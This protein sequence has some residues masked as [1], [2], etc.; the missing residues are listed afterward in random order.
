MKNIVLAHRECNGAKS[1]EIPHWD[2]FK[3]FREMT[4]FLP[5]VRGGMSLNDWRIR[6][7]E[8][9]TKLDGSVVER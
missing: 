3:A 5:K 4:G 6:L 1:D 9:R 2:A 7:R 8:E